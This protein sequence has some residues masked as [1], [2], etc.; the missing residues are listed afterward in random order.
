MSCAGASRPA[1]LFHEFL[2]HRYYLAES[3]GHD[4]DL[5]TAC[6]SYVADVLRFRPDER[7]LPG[8]EEDDDDESG[9]A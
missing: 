3:A 2:E 5:E 7:V 9:D 8:D 4:I 1:E 6:R